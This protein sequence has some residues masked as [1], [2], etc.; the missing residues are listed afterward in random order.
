MQ[1]FSWCSK[2]SLR[3]NPCAA[4]SDIDFAL[5]GWVLTPEN[6]QLELHEWT[7]LEQQHVVSTHRHMVQKCGRICQAA[8][9]Q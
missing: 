1:H 4:G 8:S 6:R 2:Q 9:N 3:W 7:N 5:A